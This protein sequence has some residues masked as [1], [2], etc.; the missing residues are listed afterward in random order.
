MRE[1]RRVG[2]TLSTR[3]PLLGWHPHPNPPPQAGEGRSGARRYTRNNACRSI[4]P[5][6]VF[7]NSSTNLT[8]RGYLYGSSLVFT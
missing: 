2:E 6:P 5:V 7:G 3:H 8:S 1:A 4:L